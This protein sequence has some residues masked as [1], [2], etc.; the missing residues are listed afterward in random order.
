[1]NTNANFGNAAFNMAYD[2]YPV[3]P[4]AAIA[5]EAALPALGG[6]AGTYGTEM[7]Q[8]NGTPQAANV[9]PAA[10]AP[11]V[12]AHPEPAAVNEM[13]IPAVASSAQKTPERLLWL[14]T[15]KLSTKLPLEAHKL[16]RGAMEKKAYQAE[17]ERLRRIYRNA[18]QA[19][20]RCGTHVYGGE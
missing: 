3:Y 11:A 4:T 10:A 2:A 19:W 7:G 14:S 9:L 16:R 20:D 6:F 8:V 17:Y 12:L 15:L 13:Q 1:M 18:H 5:D